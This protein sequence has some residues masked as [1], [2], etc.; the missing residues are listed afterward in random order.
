VDELTDFLLQARDGDREAFA[1]ALELAGPSVERFLTALVDR[2]DLDDAVQETFVRAWGALGRFRA[3]ASGR[4]WLLAIARR[5][6][7]DAV[8]ARRRRRVLNERVTALRPTTSTHL[9][10]RIVVDE[11]L[12]SLE[13]DRR[14][15]F[16]L[17]QMLGLGYEE[18]A[19]VCDVPVGT[20]RSRVARAR[21]ELLEAVAVAPTATGTA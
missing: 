18:A 1:A 6:A 19:Q 15:A 17:T 11:L 14:Q 3:E 21:A 8:R 7:A 13:P 5:T 10:E 2:E 20:I 12:A 9:G 16:L 4:T